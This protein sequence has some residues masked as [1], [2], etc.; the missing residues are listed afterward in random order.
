MIALG[1][2]ALVVAIQSAA[3]S[4]KQMAGILWAVGALFTSGFQKS[5]HLKDSSVLDI[6]WLQVLLAIVF[7]SMFVSAFLPGAKIFL[8]LVAF[9]GAVAASWCVW[10]TVTSPRTELIYLQF[11]GVW[12]AYYSVCVLWA[13]G[14]RSL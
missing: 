10:V 2:L 8:H 3:A 1:I 7:L 14:A 13:W 5:P 4:V 6:S 9:L 12:F 11:M